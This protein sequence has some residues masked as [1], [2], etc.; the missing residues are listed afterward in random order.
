MRS[1][2]TPVSVLIHQVV[3]EQ[4]VGMRDAHA[5]FAR[6]SDVVSFIKI[7]IAELCHCFALA[8]NFCNFGGIIKLVESSTL[9][10]P[11]THSLTHSLTLSLSLSLSIALFFFRNTVSLLGTLGFV[12]A[13]DTA[14]LLE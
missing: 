9:S 14:A 2:F 12:T 11:L 10:H 8:T 4:F 3:Y 7:R 13:L 1:C 6:A 5:K